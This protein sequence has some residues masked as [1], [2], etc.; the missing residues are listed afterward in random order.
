LPK[1]FTKA[2]K[3]VQKTVALGSGLSHDGG[4]TLLD[5]SEAYAIQKSIKRFQEEMKKIMVN[6]LRRNALI[7]RLVKSG[8]WKGL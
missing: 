6:R 4:R 7:Q 8:I 5:I 3:S 1:G 2:W